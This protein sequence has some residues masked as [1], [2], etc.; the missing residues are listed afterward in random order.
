MIVGSLLKKRNQE[1]LFKYFE[2]FAVERENLLLNSLKSQSQLW[3]IVVAEN[4]DLKPQFLSLNKI[5]YDNVTI[6]GIFLC[7]RVNI[8]EEKKWCVEKKWT[9]MNV[10]V[11]AAG[12][13]AGR[14]VG[15]N[16]EQRNEETA[17]III[18]WSSM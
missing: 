7:V 2:N 9:A 6:L 14:T 3:R 16:G 12:V 17:G 4:D 10:Y 13:R 15:G 11:L 1:N 8:E 5:K 18:V